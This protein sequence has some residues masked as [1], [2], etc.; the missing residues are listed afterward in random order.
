MVMLAHKLLIDKEFEVP[1]IVVLTDRIDLDNQLY[2]TFFSAKKYL[3]TECITAQSRIDLVQKLSNKKQGGIILTTIGKFDKDNLP[4]NNRNN[5]IVM[6]DEAHRSHY[7]LEESIAYERNEETYEYEQVY[8]YGIEKYIR[9]ALPNATFIGFTGTPV[10]TKE[11]Q[12]T[13]IFGEIID[14]YD[15]T[16]SVIDGATVTIS[17]ESR[18]AQIKTIDEKLKEINN[19]YDEL[20]K[21]NSSNKESIERS[22]Q[23][24]S[25]MKVILENDDVIRIL[26]QDIISHYEQRKN[27]LNGKVMIVCSTRV[28]AFKMYKE[29][30]SIKPKYKDITILVVTE[31]NKDTKEERELFGNSDYRKEIGNEF[32]K[33]TSKYKIAIVCDM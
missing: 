5:I 8:K 32:K 12:T 23:E 18:L 6:T 33:D 27:F 28:Q 19:Y 17:Y 14:T 11:K 3:K 22:K 10:S 25:K 9:D 29:I 31:S 24:M 30:I 16:Q 4:S 2:K 20:E 15:M 1:T 7:G 21:N 26:A 13:N